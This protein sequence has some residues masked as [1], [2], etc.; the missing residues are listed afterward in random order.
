M[1]V[2]GFDP[3]TGDVLHNRLQ[4]SIFGDFQSPKSESWGR[5]SVPYYPKRDEYSQKLRALMEYTN[6][7]KLPK[8]LYYSLLYCI[9][10]KG[11]LLL[12]VTDI[13]DH[14]D[15]STHG[16]GFDIQNVLPA[17]VGLKCSYIS[18]T[19]ETTPSHL[20]QALF[21]E[22][23]SASM[24]KNTSRREMSGSASGITKDASKQNIH[25]R[26]RSVQIDKSVLMKSKGKLEMEDTVPRSPK[27][28]LS[29][30][31]NQSAVKKHN[32]LER[33]NTNKHNSLERTNTN[34]NNSLERNYMGKQDPIDRNPSMRF[35]SG[36]MN[37]TLDRT[38]SS[39]VASQSRPKLTYKQSLR[40]VGDLDEYDKEHV[41][42]SESSNPR[43]IRPVSS[44][45]NTKDMRE[46]RPVASPIIR[47]KTTSQISQMFIVDRLEDA[48]HQ[49][50]AALFEIM[51]TNKFRH[52]SVNY[53]TPD[54]F[55]VIFVCR[56]NKEFALNENQLDH[57][58]L[59]INLKHPLPILPL[60][61]PSPVISLKEINSLRA[62]I[63]GIYLCQDVEQY[64][65]GI[66]SSLRNDPEVESGASPKSNFGL[67]QA[68]RA[69][70]LIFGQSFVTPSHVLSVAANV[71]THRVRM[72]E[73]A[74]QSMKAA[75]VV[76]LVLNTHIP[77]L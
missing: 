2:V 77:P 46:S 62:A 19:Q 24:G 13:D 41:R 36:Q 38:K 20:T 68:S 71:L 50:I 15:C 3:L 74:I 61:V 12:D 64:M 45:A 44:A 70:A 75:D 16:A 66:I 52:Q 4:Y 54:I 39:M 17:F 35:A 22:H 9:I 28:H 49:T 63:P 59:K 55:I 33:N 58:L 31:R 57:F 53:T 67:K 26:S 25:N 30:E 34:K 47:A 69:V 5:G 11:H 21:K 7:P 60:D 40:N 51:E 29:L 27:T 10:S 76:N 18:C 37:S 56:E 8:H 14:P 43:L 72:K 6:E 32:S 1:S 73:E 23:M 65:R 42:P 48:P